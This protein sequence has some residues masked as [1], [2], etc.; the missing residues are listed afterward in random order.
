[1]EQ[2]E[3]SAIKFIE[4]CHIYI[5]GRRENGRDIKENYISSMLYNKL[6]EFQ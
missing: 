4:V 5:R 1:M 3:V 6:A 2:I